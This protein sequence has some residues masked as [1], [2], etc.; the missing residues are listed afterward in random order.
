MATTVKK[1]WKKAKIWKNSFAPKRASWYAPLQTR[2]E[3]RLGIATLIA[4]AVILFGGV[5]SLES[6]AENNVHFAPQ[7]AAVEQ[8]TQLDATA[9]YIVRAFH[10]PSGYTDTS[11]VP[12]PSL[13]Q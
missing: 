11:K 2:V 5:F 13:G 6:Y 9:N 10:V 12:P 7:T 1:S 3:P 4:V 8:A